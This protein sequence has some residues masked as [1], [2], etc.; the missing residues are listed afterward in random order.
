MN[1]EKE[2]LLNNAK[3]LIKPIKG[4]SSLYKPNYSRNITQCLPTVYH[5]FGENIDEK[6]TF[7]KDST[8]RKEII[9]ISDFDVENIIFMVIDSLGF[10][11]FLDYTN[12]LSK[13]LVFPVS[14]VFPSITSSAIMSIHTGSFPEEHGILGYKI[15]FDELGVL[16]NTLKLST[17]KAQY[18]DSLTKVGVDFS[19][20]IW[21]KSMHFNEY[22]KIMDVSLYAHNIAYTGLSTLINKIENTIAYG[23]LID[24]ISI[25]SKLI[26]MKKF[27]KKLIHFYIDEIDYLSHLYGPKSKHVEFSIKLLEEKLLFLKKSISNEEAKKTLLFIVSDHGQ[28]EVNPEKIVRFSEDEINQLSN[29]LRSK[30]GKSGRTLHFYTEDSK[31]EE[32][33]QLL[34]IK[35]ENKG[36]V[37]T[38]N[39]LYETLEIEHINF[40]ENVR[41]RIGDI[42]VILTNE[43]TASYKKDNE[44]EGEELIENELLG[45]HGGISFEELCSLTALI[46]LSEL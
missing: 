16:V 18:R 28:H 29:L 8:I 46:K 26:K 1:I 13:S 43:N 2:K 11:Q 35:F 6:R 27:N 30:P 10:T 20:F 15:L 25:I 31:I 39:E 14:S 4:Y 9:S 45:Q 21:E 3:E 23:N 24:G 33:K 12:I 22:N 5:I 37:F 40:R 36:C 34:E 44:E 19:K 32:V 42:I 7:L 41:N 17:D 38:F